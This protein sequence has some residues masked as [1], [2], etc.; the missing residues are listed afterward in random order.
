MKEQGNPEW[1]ILGGS[2]TRVCDLLT[3]LKEPRMKDKNIEEIKT[4]LFLRQFV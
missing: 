1:E 3:A 4:A 2:V